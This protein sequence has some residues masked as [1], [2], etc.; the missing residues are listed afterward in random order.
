MVKTPPSNTRGTSSILGG[1][2]RCHRMWP[3]SKKK[4]KKKK[5]GLHL[6]HTSGKQIKTEPGFIRFT[7]SKMKLSPYPCSVIFFSP[8]SPN[9]RIKFPSAN[10]RVLL[11]SLKRIRRT[12]CLD[13]LLS[14]KK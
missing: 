3:K 8:K 6:D 10:G 7:L 14:T 1:E 13:I 4:R 11:C 12:G 2:L 9:P 5:L